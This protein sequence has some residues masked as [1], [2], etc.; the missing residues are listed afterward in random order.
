MRWWFIELFWISWWLM[1]L[2][3]RKITLKDWL[4]LMLIDTLI[5][6]F[7][8][9]LTIFINAVV[10]K[11]FEIRWTFDCWVDWTFDDSAKNEN[12]TKTYEKI[13]AKTN[14]K[15]DVD[16]NAEIDVTKNSIDANSTDAT[17]H[18]RWNAFFFNSFF[19]FRIIENNL[20]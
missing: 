6:R 7:L 4:M 20:S 19:R 15:F 13:D 1:K 8:R 11:Y 16:A 9:I 18:S 12:V 5:I 3:T 10:E 14:V 17:R 2:I